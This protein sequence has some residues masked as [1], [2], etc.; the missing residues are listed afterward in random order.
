MVINVD[1]ISPP[2]GITFVQEVCKFHGLLNDLGRPRFKFFLYHIPS[3]C[4]FLRS[5]SFL[6]FQVYKVYYQLREVG[7]C[8]GTGCD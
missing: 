2:F 1:N 4:A 3:L 5:L 6:L 8:H 7:N